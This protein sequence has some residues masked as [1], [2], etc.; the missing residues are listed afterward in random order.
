VNY[1]RFLRE[2]RI[3]RSTIDK[4]PG[5]GPKTKQNLIRTFGS[6][7]GIRRASREEL[8]RVVRN[9]RVVEEIVRWSRETVG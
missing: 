2:R 6:V 9:R 3:S 8:I 4:V 7:A 1:H 5:V